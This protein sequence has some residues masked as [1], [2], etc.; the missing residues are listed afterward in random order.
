[1]S[2]RLPN[3]QGLSA[4][5]FRLRE[6]VTG[7]LY[8]ATN[9]ELASDTALADSLID[10]TADAVVTGEYKVE[11]PD[12]VPV[13]DY[14]LVIYDVAKVSVTATTVPY[15]HIVC[16]IDESGKAFLI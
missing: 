13:G 11:I 8:D 3:L 4:A 9:E 12:S 14:E 16:R 10:C 6:M 15:R 5:S 1:M 2:K 7:K